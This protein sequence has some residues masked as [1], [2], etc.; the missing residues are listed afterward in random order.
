MS[1]IQE[2]RDMTIDQ[3]EVYIEDLDKQLFKFR[4]QLAS[5]KRLE[6]PHLIKDKRRDKARALMVL[7][8]KKEKVH[9]KKK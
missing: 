5:M 7:N 1:N 8:E 6:K 3:L 2:L 9:G 4:N